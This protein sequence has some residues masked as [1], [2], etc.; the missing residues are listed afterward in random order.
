MIGAA[1]ELLLLFV[2]HRSTC[3]VS[4]VCRSDTLWVFVLWLSCGLMS[5]LCDVGNVCSECKLSGQDEVNIYRLLLHFTIGTSSETR[6]YLQIHLSIMCCQSLVL[7]LLQGPLAS[8][9]SLAILVLHG[10]GEV[11][12]PACVVFLILSRQQEG[13]QNLIPQTTESHRKLSTAIVV[14]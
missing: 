7:L 4:L 8:F 12:I 11:S 13:C 2:W 6:R 1:E 3:V 9:V 10:Y 5:I 14:P